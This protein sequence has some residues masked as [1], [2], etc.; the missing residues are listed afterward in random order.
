[1]SWYSPTRVSIFYVFKNDGHLQFF[2]VAGGDAEGGAAEVGE[3][4]GEGVGAVGGG[5]DVALEAAEAAAENADRVAEAVNGGGKLDGIVALSEHELE[6]CYFDIGDGGCRAVEAS[7]VNG[8]VDHEPVDVRK[9]YYVAALLLGASDEY[10]RR[11]DNALNGFAASI[12]PHAG[13]GLC[14]HVIFHVDLLQLG[15]CAFFVARVNHSHKPF[16]S[17]HAYGAVNALGHCR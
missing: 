14:S 16:A 15:A 6:L 2:E 11:Y 5:G 4:D 9:S 17:G 7:G 10:H 3:A 12:A 13:L 8:A 1:M